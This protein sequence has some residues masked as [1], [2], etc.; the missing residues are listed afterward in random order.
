LQQLV[1][2][3][4]D[5]HFGDNVVRLSLIRIIDNLAPLF[6]G[7]H[8]AAV[9]TPYNLAESSLESTLSPSM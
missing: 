2:D 1:T 5:R 3:S 8:A 4:G 9:D 6:K 7:E